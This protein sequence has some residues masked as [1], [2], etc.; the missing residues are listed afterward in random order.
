MIKT[1]SAKNKMIRLY[2]GVCYHC[3]KDVEYYSLKKKVRS[4]IF[5]CLGC[6][7]LFIDE[8]KPI[9]NRFEILD[10]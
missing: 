10:L 1:S 9:E 5:C 2:H 6:R 7:E 8:N 3:G 4:Y